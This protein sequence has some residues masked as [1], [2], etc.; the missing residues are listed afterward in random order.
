MKVL[1]M[2]SLNLDYVYTVDHIL[3]G[4][5]TLAS[6]KMEVFCGGKGL[7]QSI[8]MAKAGVP[9]F[10]AGLIGEEGE[11]LLAVCQE[12]GVDTGYIQK[13]EGKSGHTIIQ[14]DKEAQNCILL[15]GGS[16]RSFTKEYIDRVL[17]H[18]GEGDLLILQN[19]INLLDYVVDRAYDKNMVI[20]LNP[21]PMDE[22]LEAVDMGKISIF[23]MNEIEGAQI[24]GT[25]NPEDVLAVMKEKFPQARVVLTL[26]R[27]GCIYQDS[28][29]LC[30]QSAYEVKAVD[31]TAAGDTFTGYFIA[32]LLKGM[33]IEGILDMCARAS[34]IAVSRKGAAASIPMMEEVI[35]AS[36]K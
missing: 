9:V 26:G 33:E 27:D 18:F 13:I 36:Q 6:K 19:E 30:R 17:E 34:A 32:G 15:Y 12:N 23:L 22:A 8:A 14:V 25:E 31:T 21:S 16:N 2:G 7:N 35:R 11:P 10:H 29:K 5:E 28:E 24:A 1:N 20:I 3:K 4:G